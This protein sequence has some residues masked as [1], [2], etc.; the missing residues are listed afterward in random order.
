MIDCSDRR[1]ID[2]TGGELQELLQEERLAGV[3]LLV[4]ANKQDLLNAMKEDEVCECARATCVHMRAKPAFFPIP[5]P[6]F[7]AYGASF[8]LLPSTVL[9]SPL[10][11][12]A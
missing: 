12:D 11:L 6:V 10:R 3:P 2:E 9:S 8:D 7:S 4:F 1:R 5:A